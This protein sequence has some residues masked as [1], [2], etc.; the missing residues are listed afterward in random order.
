[1]RDKDFVFGAEV[2]HSVMKSWPAGLGARDSSVSLILEADGRVSGDLEVNPLYLPQLRVASPQSA[3]ATLQNGVLEKRNSV[4]L[5]TV[6]GLME[7]NYL[8][9]FGR[10]RVLRAKAALE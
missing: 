3:M 10:L 1:M 2:K 5:V 7:G 4:S 6:W 8:F 9:S